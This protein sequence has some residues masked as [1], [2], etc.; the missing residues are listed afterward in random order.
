MITVS[1]ED[2]KALSGISGEYKEMIESLMR[3]SQ[4]DPDD[5]TTRQ[6]ALGINIE[7][8]TRGAQP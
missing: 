3:V 1:S 4:I 6:T 2:L 8:S 5:F 7:K